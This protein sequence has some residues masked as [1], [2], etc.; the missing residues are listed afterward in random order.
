[1]DKADAAPVCDLYLAI[2]V[3]LKDRFYN[4]KH[5]PYAWGTIKDSVLDIGLCSGITDHR[6]AISENMLFVYSVYQTMTVSLEDPLFINKAVSFV[7][8]NGSRWREP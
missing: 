5:F 8:G 4:L 3:E 6:I 2:L 7:V 1:M